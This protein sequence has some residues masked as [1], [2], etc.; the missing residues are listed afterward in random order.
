MKEIALVPRPTRRFCGVVPAQDCEELAEAMR[1]LSGIFTSRS[2]WHVN[3]TSTSG[4]VAELLAATLPYLAGAGI[5]VHWL[6]IDA[7]PSFFEV[8]KRV[9]NRLHEDRGDGGKLGAR[10]RE[11]Y[12]HAIESECPLIAQSIAAGDVVVLHDPQTLGLA[13][14]LAARGAL[15]LWRCHIG[16]DDAGPLARDGWDF[17]Q[18]YL[19][20]V[21]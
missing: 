5:D 9:H 3:S 10:E 11:I 2:L 15:V 21:R 19:S 14:G 17:L 12:E 16:V 7:D 20:G 6:V 4:G 13:P 18:R 8:T 1:G